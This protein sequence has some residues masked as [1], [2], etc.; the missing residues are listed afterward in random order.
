MNTFKKNKVPGGTIHAK[1][2]EQYSEYLIKN[3]AAS[4]TW[5]G[6]SAL[7]RNEWICWITSAKKTETTLK[8]IIQA[9]EN[10]ADGKRRPCC[11]AGCPHRKNEK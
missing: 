4:A 7:A 9:C 1:I 2:P 6:I 8:R 3:N 10:L 5:L 11:W